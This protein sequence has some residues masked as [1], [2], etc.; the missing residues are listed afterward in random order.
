[1]PKM[2]VIAKAQI[3]ADGTS[4]IEFERQGKSVHEVGSKQRQ[5]SGRGIIKQRTAL[6]DQQPR[7]EQPEN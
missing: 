5:T 1:M 4:I 3:K 7:K 6:K 2:V